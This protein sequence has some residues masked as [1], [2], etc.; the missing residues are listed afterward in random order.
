MDAKPPEMHSVDLVNSP[1]G[2]GLAL[3]GRPSPYRGSRILCGQCQQEVEQRPKL[4]P[5]CNLTPLACVPTQQRLRWDALIARSPASLE[6][7]L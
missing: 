3:I 4:V 2:L 7:A 6:R 5:S 1:D